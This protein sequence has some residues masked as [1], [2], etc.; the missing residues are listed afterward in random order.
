[1]TW[2]DTTVLC[3]SLK[4]THNYLTSVYIYWTLD[5]FKHSR[6]ITMGTINQRIFSRLV[7]KTYLLKDI[8]L[9]L[10]PL[11]HVFKNRS[12]YYIQLVWC[13]SIY[14]ELASYIVLFVLTNLRYIFLFAMY[15]IYYIW[16]TVL[17]RF[18]LPWFKIR[19]NKVNVHM[20]AS[21]LM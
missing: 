15:E 14:L 11:G 19:I 3:K 17:L 20:Y 18:R 8:Y 9:N 4:T 7:D 6:H 2:S 16:F 5:N 10:R 13:S 21:W 1:M 12:I